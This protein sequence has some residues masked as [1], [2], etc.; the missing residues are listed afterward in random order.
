[1]DNKDDRPSN[2]QKFDSLMR[3]NKAISPSVPVGTK[4]ALESI[5]ERADEIRK[6]RLDIIGKIKANTIE[7]R[8]G[9]EAIHAMYKAQIEAGTHALQRAVEVEKQRVDLVANKYIYQITQEYLRDMNDLGMH[10]YTARVETLFRLSAETTRLL[11]Q[12]ESQAVP[13]SLKD[14]TIAA[15]IKKHTEFYER[16]VADEIALSDAQKK[17]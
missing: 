16:I 11:E 5:P 6:N 9:L 12:A 4:Q 3:Q 15:I 13:Q 8:A 10:N 17:P 2:W 1:V 7:R 14:Q